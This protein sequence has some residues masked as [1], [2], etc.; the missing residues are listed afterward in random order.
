MGKVGLISVNLKT[1]ANQC[2]AGWLLPSLIAEPVYHL[3]TV[4]ILPWKKLCLLFKTKLKRSFECNRPTTQ[5]WKP[6]EG[7]CTYGLFHGLPCKV[8]WWYPQRHCKKKLQ[9][10]TEYWRKHLSYERF[11]L[12]EDKDDTSNSSAGLGAMIPPTTRPYAE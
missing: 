1:K 12:G 3:K 5:R 10:A 9:K 8:Y 7:L 6:V 2:P 4:M 11:P